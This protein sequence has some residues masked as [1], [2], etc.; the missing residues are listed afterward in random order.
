MTT[1]SVSRFRPNI[2]NLGNATHWI[3]VV[4]LIFFLLFLVST[5]QLLKQ[6]PNASIHLQQSNLNSH[7]RYELT[8]I[9]GKQ[10][11]GNFLQTDLHRY[12]D[13]LSNI[14]WVEQADVRRDW[15]QGLIVNVTPRKAVA[16]FGSERL[17]DADGVVFKP[18]D[19]SELDA[20]YW[21][22]L[23]GDEK[24][25]VAMMQQVQ[26]VSDWYLPLGLKVKE[27][28]VSSRMTWLFRFDNG[29]RV[30]VGNDNT[31]EKLYHL[32]VMLQNQLHTKL[33]KM[34]S[35]DLRYKNG[36][37]VTWKTTNDTV[38]NDGKNTNN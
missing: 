10:A 27:V 7:E 11:D 9:L 15:Q 12:V 38:V 23:Q 19:P 5:F 4:V 17:V 8:K 30:L 35:I 16:K 26:Q 18:A 3:V 1:T 13:T 36:M 29:L 33:P 2:Q 24:D 28:I 21:M 25:A 34:Q 20:H 22:Q 37:A 31:S 6:L 14:G 32:S